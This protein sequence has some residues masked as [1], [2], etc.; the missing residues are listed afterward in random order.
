MSSSFPKTLS[1][2][3]T[4]GGNSFGFLRF[5]LAAM[6]IFS[7]AIPIGGFGR[8]QITARTHET[9]GSLAVSCFFVI[10]GFLITASYISQRSLFRFSWHRIL[11]I[12]PGF[13]GCLLVTIFLFAPAQ[14][15]I[16]NGTLAGYWPGAWQFFNANKWLEMRQYQIG[17]LL[18]HH[19]HPS[20][21]DGSLWSLIYEFKCYIL[22]AI[23]GFFGVLALA[24]PV[25]LLT[26]VITFGLYMTE[27]MYPGGAGRIIPVYADGW[28][29]KLT[30]YFLAGM[31]AYL[32]REHISLSLRLAVGAAVAIVYSLA[33][34]PEM[35]PFLAVLAVPY[36]LLYLA[37]VLPW[38]NFDKRADISY[39]VYLYGFSVQQLL[40]T[41]GL[42]SLG[43]WPYA[44]LSLITTIPFAAASYYL[45]ERPML[46]L[47]HFSLLSRVQRLLQ[48]F[49]P[50]REMP[51]V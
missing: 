51:S 34:C 28:M 9:F 22:V 29:L 40:V 27:S 41:F 35:Y 26:F 48:V 30:A 16:E 43:Y 24:R 46:R 21:W 5:A 3:L 19:P 42:H 39:G 45:I 49:S 20:A 47:K 36:L 50:A 14:C 10:S 4:K 44:I 13:Y 2:I 38:S 6:V 32:Y 1:H 8:E 31:V 17:G 25:V 37:A 18:A 11:R 7:H 23:L 33:R 15:L 12:L